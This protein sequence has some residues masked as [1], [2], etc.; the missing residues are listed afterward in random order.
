MV[1]GSARDFGFDEAEIAALRKA[2]II[3]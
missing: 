1:S 3:A 2:H